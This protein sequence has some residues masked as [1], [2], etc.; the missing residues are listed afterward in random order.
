MIHIIDD[1][2]NV[3]DGFSLLLNSAGYKCHSFESAEQFLEYYEKHHNDDLIIL[4]IHLQGMNGCDL[5]EH[6]AKKELHLPVIILTAYDEPT[7]RIAVKKYGAVAYLR[8]PVD[9]EALIDLI[10][11]NTPIS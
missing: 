9:S 11:F 8:K 6:L 4:D 2:P 5:L 7:T 10:K 1:D 3:R